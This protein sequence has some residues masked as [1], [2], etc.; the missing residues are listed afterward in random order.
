MSGYRTPDYNAAL[1]NGRYSRHLWGGAADIYV[2]VAP[3]DDV[4]DDLNQDGKIDTRDADVLN[5]LIDRLVDQS[6]PAIAQ[7]GL[8]SY[9][10]T[11]SHGPYVHVDARGWDAR[12]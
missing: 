11:P 9:K 5:A 6:A 8:S 1:G 12:W 2:D 3:K 4:M 7:G 10:A